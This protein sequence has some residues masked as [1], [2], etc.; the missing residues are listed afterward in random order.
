MSQSKKLDSGIGYYLKTAFDY[1]IRNNIDIKI[2]QIVEDPQKTEDDLELAELK[3]VKEYL[4]Q[5]IGEL[6]T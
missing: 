4:N 1:E 5:R 2:A 3:R 6:K